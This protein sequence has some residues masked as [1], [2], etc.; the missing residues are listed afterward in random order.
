MDTPTEKQ[1]LAH[2]VGSMVTIHYLTTYSDTGTLS[3]LDSYWVELIKANGERLLIPT[4]AIRV[5]KLQEAVNK[6]QNTLLRPSSGSSPS[7][8]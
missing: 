8:E 2:Y 5:I 6:E 1:P 3:Y 7:Q 4:N